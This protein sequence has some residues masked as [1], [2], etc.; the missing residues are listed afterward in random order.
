MWWHSVRAVC[1]IT[2]SNEENTPPQQSYCIELSNLGGPLEHREAADIF[3]NDLTL[4]EQIFLPHHLLFA[5]VV[6]ASGDVRGVLGNVL[7]HL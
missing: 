3:F 7:G 6:Y 1:R 5:M 2:P 4:H